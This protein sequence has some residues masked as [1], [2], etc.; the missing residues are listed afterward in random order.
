MEIF[1]II[2]IEYC[3]LVSTWICWAEIKLGWRGTPWPWCILSIKQWSLLNTP[4]NKSYH[5]CSDWFRCKMLL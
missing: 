1:L 3:V 2:L 4:S 5:W